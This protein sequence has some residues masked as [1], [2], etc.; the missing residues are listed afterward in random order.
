MSCLSPQSLHGVHLVAQCC[1]VRGQMTHFSAHAPTSP[2]HLLSLSAVCPITSLP[3]YPIFIIFIKIVTFQPRERGRMRFHAIQNVETA[4][5]F[6]RSVHWLWQKFQNFWQRSDPQVQG[7]QAGQHQGGG[8]CGRQPQ[9]HTR[10]HLDNHPPLPGRRE[11]KRATFQISFCCCKL[12]SFP[13]LS[14]Q[15]HTSYNRDQVLDL[16]KRFYRWCKNGKHFLCIKE[17]K[18]GAKQASTAA[19]HN[20]QVDVCMLIACLLEHI[21]GFRAENVCSFQNPQISGRCLHDHRVS[22]SV[23]RQILIAASGY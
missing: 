14:F 18:F 17:I 5:R 20:S 23:L 12:S 15:V 21:F 19:K 11:R 9:A 4:L 13:S 7:D 6:L 10:P 16:L 3:F 2:T 8:H 22:F 1:P